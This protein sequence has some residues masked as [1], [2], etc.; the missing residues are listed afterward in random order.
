MMQENVGRRQSLHGSDPDGAT[1]SA[2][3]PPSTATTTATATTKKKESPR[4][5]GLLHL[6]LGSSS[7][8][9]T[10]PLNSFS[11][12]YSPPLPIHLPQSVGISPRNQP[13]PPPRSPANALAIAN[14][15]GMANGEAIML[16]ELVD[17]YRG[18]MERLRS[19]LN[20][21]RHENSALAEEIHSVM[22]QVNAAAAALH[23]H[24]HDVCQ[25]ATT[26]AHPSQEHD[27][28]YP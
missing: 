13:F 24:R 3:S 27:A 28:A 8:P 5:P 22:L 4:P 2:S 6:G 18:E 1:S 19:E 26:R 25:T 20:I 9:P 17:K 23:E 11:P 21:L 7:S 16:R 10:A 14:G 15:E 12:S